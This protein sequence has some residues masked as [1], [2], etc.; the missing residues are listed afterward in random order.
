MPQIPLGSPLG[1]PYNHISN[2]GTFVVKAKPGSLFALNINS[3]TAG[4]TVTLFDQT[5]T[6]TGTVEIALINVGTSDILPLSLPFGPA[7]NGINFT[8]G[9]VALTTGTVDLTV[10]YR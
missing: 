5:T 3:G 10:A 4:A 6:A 9:L 2:A 8:N 7:G 1:V